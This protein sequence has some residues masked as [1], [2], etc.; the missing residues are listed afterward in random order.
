MGRPLSEADEAAF[1]R[2]V[3]LTR[4][5][6]NVEVSTSYGMPGLKVGGKVFANLCS[7]PGALAVHCPLET[8]AIL[9]EAAP[10]LYFDTPHFSGWPSVLVRMGAIGDGP[11]AVRLEAAWMLRAPKPLLRRRREGRA[12]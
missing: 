2:A 11:L 5:L 12:D 8:K 10:D 7:E 1:A 9:I 3:R 4:D 6:P